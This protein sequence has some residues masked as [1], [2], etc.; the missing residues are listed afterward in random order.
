MLIQG[1][2]GNTFTNLQTLTSRSLSLG[3]TTSL[4]FGE[5]GSKSSE[6]LIHEG[7]WDG[8]SLPWLPSPEFL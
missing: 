6:G 1:I 5:L 2:P 3:L 8:R 7:L 4:R